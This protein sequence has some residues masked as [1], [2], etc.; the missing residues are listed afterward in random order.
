[1]V[2]RRR[3][4]ERTDVGVFRRGVADPQGRRQLDEPVG[5]LRPGLRVHVDPPF[6]AGVQTSIG[7]PDSRQAPARNIGTGLASMG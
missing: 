7:W 3:A 6:P 1:M 4:D 5:E 2:G